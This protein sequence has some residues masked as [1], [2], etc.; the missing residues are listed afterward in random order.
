M[1]KIPIYLFFCYLA[2]LPL[3]SILVISAESSGATYTRLLSISLLVFVLLNFSVWKKRVKLT[4]EMLSAIFFILYGVLSTLWAIDAQTAINRVPV[5]VS[6]LLFYLAVTAYPINMND[7]KNAMYIYVFGACIASLYLFK[8]FFIEGV[9]YV[10]DRASLIYGNKTTDPNQFAFSLLLP[11]ALS[12]SMSFNCL[13]YRG[14]FLSAMATLLLLSA[15]VLTGSRGGI[16]GAVI[17]FGYL[18]V[19]NRSLKKTIFLVVIPL[20][21]YLFFVDLL[22]SRFSIAISSGGAG[23]LDIWEIGYSAFLD[24]LIFGCGLNNF[25][26]VFN[27][28]RISDYTLGFGRGSHS[29]FVGTMVEL[30][31]V[32]FVSM[33][34]FFITHYRSLKNVGK[35]FSL[36]L[37]AAFFGLMVH[38]MTLDTLWRKSFWVLF[39]FISFAYF[40]NS[41]KPQNV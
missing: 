36:P 7:Y 2:L 6:L 18:L 21:T 13:N 33:L 19:S 38:S 29:I 34:V 14:K 24:N 11:L 32:G 20:T 30:G 40:L 12:A 28:H 16:L 25:P 35:E 23:R 26:V 9:I 15:I 3:D 1:A 37:K 41:R 27:F 39:V 8:L 22:Q 17:I 5:A 31:V 10:S 4:P